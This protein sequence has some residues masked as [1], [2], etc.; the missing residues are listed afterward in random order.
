VVAE[1]KPRGQPG[2]VEGAGE[3]GRVGGRRA[4]AAGSA[5]GGQHQRGG[6]SQ[7]AAAVVQVIRVVVV[8]DQHQVYRPELVLADRRAGG[9]GEVAMGTG[10][11]EGGV[12]DNAQATDVE[13]GGRAAQHHGRALLPRHHSSTLTSEADSLRQS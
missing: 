5:A 4:E 12:A 13:D 6:K 2:V 9:L 3:D 1:A 10:G 7:G 11:I 8:A